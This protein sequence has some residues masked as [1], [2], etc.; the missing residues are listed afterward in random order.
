MVTTH[1]VH[2]PLVVTTRQERLKWYEDDQVQVDDTAKEEVRGRELKGS[3]LVGA[4]E[5]AHIPITNNQ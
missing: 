2:L 4:M 5:G 3:G 1:L